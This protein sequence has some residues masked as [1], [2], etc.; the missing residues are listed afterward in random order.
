MSAYVNR[1]GDALQMF[2]E[3]KGERGRSFETTC[4][5]Y[6]TADKLWRQD[7][8]NTMRPVWA[9][10]AGSAQEVGAF[11]ENLLL[12]HVAKSDLRPK[13][14]DVTRMEF[15][16][17]AGYRH[18]SRTLSSGG[19]VHTFALPSLL[20]ATPPTEDRLRLR[21]VAIPARA[22]LAQQTFDLNTARVRLDALV[23]ILVA[24]R[25]F[26]AK[27]A[28]TIPWD[29]RIELTQRDDDPRTVGNG[30]LHYLLALG[31]L[32]LHYLDARNPRPVPCD[33]VFGAWLVML[34]RRDGP[35]RTEADTA[36][37]SDGGNYD[38]YQSKKAGA[39]PGFMFSPSL[40]GAQRRSSPW[41]K[42]VRETRDEPTMLGDW[43]APE[44][45]RWVK[46]GG[47]L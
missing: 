28:K 10:F 16:R 12:G 44:V 41:D 30:R 17:S 37:T 35:L 46:A 47:R 7:D 6:A 40:I 23:E 4:V 14:R 18:W 31:A 38:V 11:A 26:E 32:L 33:P 22:W 13:Q 34:G 39:L 29:F 1:R 25:R 5:A 19:A 2:I 42:P 20:D 15:V 3:P 36:Y 45:M 21:F 8:G 27:A 24:E 9:V 43:L